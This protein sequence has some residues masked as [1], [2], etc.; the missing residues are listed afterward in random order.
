M[1]ENQ[2]MQRWG[3]WKW[4]AAILG[5]TVIAVAAFIAINAWHVIRMHKRGWEKPAAWPIP[6][7]TQSKDTTG[8]EA[9]ELDCGISAV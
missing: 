6:P 2:N 3:F 1:A 7:A 8:H 9:E 5:G 4:L